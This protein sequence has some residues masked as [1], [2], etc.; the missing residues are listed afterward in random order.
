MTR[1]TGGQAIVE[2]LLRHGVDTVFGLPGAQTYGLFDALHGQSRRIRVVGARHE[3][4]C[5]Y[6]AL[7]YARATGRPGVFSVVPGPGILNASAALLTA[8][9]VNAP[10]LAITGQVPSAYF[11]RGRGHLHEMRDQLGTIRGFTKWAERIEHPSEAPMKVA[12]ALRQSLSGRR[13][14]VALES[15][16]DTFTEVAEVTLADPMPPLPSPPVDTDAIEQAARMIADARAPMIFVGGGAIEASSDILELARRL[17]A[18]VV[19]LR[20]GRGIVSEADDHGHNMHSAHELWP[21]TDL[22]VA[23]GTRLE[24]L[25]WRWSGRPEGLRSIRIDI[26]P[27]EFRRYPCDLD[28]LADAADGMRALNE[29]LSRK[30]VHCAPRLERMREA[31]ARTLAAA[32][33]SVQPQMSYLKVMRDVLPE[34]GIIVDDLSQVGFTS[35]F[36]F[37]VYHPRTYLQSGYQGTLGSGYGTALG[38]KVAFPDRPVLSFCGDGGFMFAVQELATAVQ[39]NIALPV[40]VFNNRSFANVRRDQ[41]LNFGGNLMLADLE[42]PEFAKLAEAFGIRGVTVTSPEAL[43]PEL[44]FAL[45]N[46]APSLIEVRLDRGSEGNPWPFIHPKFPSLRP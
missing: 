2:Q 1:L 27:A 18:P 34:D 7:G 45:G 28:I 36:G 39:Y 32:E 29:A 46:N 4:A 11:G 19:S 22:I 41:T 24:I 37:P 9:G 3:Q 30:R 40:V 10:V 8:L 21:D 16:W 38:A 42:N 13:G 5:G 26:D 14:P 43:R 44:E 31:K 12:E 17:S 33:A 20:N 25:G 6:M 15:F 35:W 23:I